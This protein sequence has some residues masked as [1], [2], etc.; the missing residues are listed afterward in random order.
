MSRSC[1]ARMHGVS[2]FGMRRFS[3]NDPTRRRSRFKL[4]KSFAQTCY[5]FAK[6][7][8]ACFPRTP[9]HQRSLGRE[10]EGPSVS[11]S[12]LLVE[13]RGH[14]AGVLASLR[15][16][17]VRSQS[18][19]RDALNR[20]RRQAALWIAP[21]MSAVKLLLETLPRRPMGDQRL[22]SLGAASGSI[23]R[24][25][26][27]ALFRFVVSSD[28]GARLLPTSELVE[29][30]GSENR[31]DLLI[32]ATL[33]SDTTAIVY[34]GNLEPL[35]VP[36]SWFRSRHEGPRP[37]SSKLQV[38]DFGHTLKLGEYE[39]ATDAILYEFDAEYRRRAKQEQ[40]LAD[41]TLGGA[42]RR[43]RLQKGLRQ[44]D[45]P[46]LTAKEIARIERGEVKRPHRSTLEV[47]AT[48]LGVAPEEISTY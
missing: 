13:P 4:S 38:T 12:L 2:V 44:S 11:E 1:S 37:D 25:L 42:L 5:R 7:G 27:H 19:I 48:H 10:S 9:S 30:L 24:G 20:I 47:I 43:L 31:T 6:P 46:G 22:L 14:G 26:L 3:T 29:V 15:A 18:D 32:G 36:L 8:I 45:F 23:P 40:R 21:N 17:R 41:R 28:E 33:A 39:A 34:R 35:V 16:D